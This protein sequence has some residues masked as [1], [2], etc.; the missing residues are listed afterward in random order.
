MRIA[1]VGDGRMGRAVA[2]R[3]RERGHDVTAMLGIDDNPD[4]TGIDRARL[5]E[6]DVAIEFT[7]PSSAVRNV[8]ACARAGI[9]VVVGTTGWYAELDAVTRE[10]QAARGTMLWA[11]NFSIG[12]AIITIAM[13]A[14]AAAVRR[15][16]GFDAHLI[17]THHS[18]KK[19]QPSG[20]AI[21]LAD[22]AGT[23]LGR[24]I[25]IT[26]VRT[27]HVPGTHELVFDAPF[28]KLRILHEA[29]DRRVFADGAVAAAEWLRGRRGIYTMRDVVEL[30]GDE[31]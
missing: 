31:R 22:A 10:V 12:V 17:E 27:G 3:A 25:P 26:S 6:P 13:E 8:V 24:T 9:P 14:V 30:T 2:E 21:A 16:G 20:T 28:E 19:D 18:A 29:R 11:P 5:G 4:G 15:A 7:E 1:L 23:F